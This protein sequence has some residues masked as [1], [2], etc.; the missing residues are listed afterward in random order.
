MISKTCTF[1][2]WIIESPD[3][4]TKY[5]QELYAQCG[6]NEGGFVFSEDGNE[7]DLSKVADMIMNPLGL[8]LNEKKIVS[9]LHLELVKTSVSEIMYEKTAELTRYI[10]DYIMNLEDSANYTIQF[11]E[12]LDMAVLLKAMDVKYEEIEESLLEHLVRYIKLVVDLLDVRLLVF[13]NIRSYLND[14]QFAA[15]IQEIEYQ[16]IKVLFIENQEK[17]C[18]EGGMRYIID[19]DG[20][21][22]Y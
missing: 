19:K 9:K 4:F 21:E 20:C 14:D 13:V 7:I 1:S 11:S 5:V 15:L 3:L 10:A 12:K 2:E 22:I 18:V 8:D 17:G 16:E 6:K